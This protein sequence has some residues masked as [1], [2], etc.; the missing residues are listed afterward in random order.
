MRSQPS[1]QR[2]VGTLADEA[3]KKTKGGAVFNEGDTIVP[4]I[5]NVKLY[6]LARRQRARP[7]RRCRKGDEMIFMGEEKDGFLK[8]ES[9]NGGGWVKKVLVSK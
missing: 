2:D 3:G 6:R 5:G 4:K 8:V 9:G 1:L 7:S